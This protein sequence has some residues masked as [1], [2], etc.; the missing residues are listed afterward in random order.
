MSLRKSSWEEQ[1]TVI[2]GP[3]KSICAQAANGDDRFAASISF[4]LAQFGCV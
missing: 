2:G 4:L 1:S 3:E